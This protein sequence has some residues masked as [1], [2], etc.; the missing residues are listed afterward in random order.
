MPINHLDCSSKCLRNFL[1]VGNE[2]AMYISGD[3]EIYGHYDLKKVESLFALFK[4]SNPDRALNIIEIV[5]GENALP[6][7][8]TLF[9]TLAAALKYENL[10]PQM[11]NKIYSTALSMFKTS[12]DLFVFIKFVSKLNKNKIP[13]GLQK[14]IKLYYSQKDPVVLSNEIVHNNG[15]FGW[16]HKDLIKLSHIKTDNECKKQ[17]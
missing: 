3:P 1:Y 6:L 4:S 16:S 8:K 11:R 2:E 13:S 14:I 17:I 10:T 5:N 9:F 15:Y 12:E 7:R